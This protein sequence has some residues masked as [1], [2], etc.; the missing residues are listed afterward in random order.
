MIGM[1]V[2]NGTDYVRRSACLYP[3]S[4]L[5]RFPR[6]HLCGWRG[7]GDGG[8]V[9]PLSVRSALLARRPADRLKWGGN[10]NWLLTRCAEEFFCYWQHDDFT[11]GNYLEEL[12]RAATGY[13]NAVCY[14]SDL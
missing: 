4:E 9:P 14:Y 8:R 6:S 11:S 3:R 5:C 13:P 2:Y 10:F 1:P 12:V 7:R